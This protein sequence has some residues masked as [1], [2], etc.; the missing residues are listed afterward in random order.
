MKE[1]GAMLKAARE[2]KG[3]SLDEIQMVTKIRYKHLE[4]LEAGDFDKIPGEVYVKGFLVN[5][6]KNVGLDG[7]QILQKYYAAK[8]QKLQ[9]DE[10]SLTQAEESLGVLN[11]TVVPEK[12]PAKRLARKKPAFLIP[13]VIGFLLV[14]VIMLWALLPSASDSQE[15]SRMETPPAEE[16][17]L[18]EERVTGQEVT[19][20]EEQQLTVET[21]PTQEE[22][23]ALPGNTPESLLSVQASEVVWLG[24]YGRVSERVIFEGTL[25]PDERQEWA[26]TEDVTLRIGNAGGLR[27]NYGGADL[28]PLG[29]SG[30]VITKVITVD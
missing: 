12:V 20:T 23:E 11:E 22:R 7:E 14:V 28:G 16:H 27:V 15:A 8:E 2:G 1:I 9:V 24:V 26:L 18:A 17:E 19:R 30:Q 5:F 25:Y 3:L 10:G 13:V 29:Y 4:A 6:A 21:G